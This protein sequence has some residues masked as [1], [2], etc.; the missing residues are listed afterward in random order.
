MPELWPLSPVDLPWVDRVDRTACGRLYGV[1]E[2]NL[3]EE[4]STCG[5]G[6]VC[7]GGHG[8]RTAGGPARHTDSA[9]AQERKAEGFADLSAGRLNLGLRSAK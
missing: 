3:T 6:G 5:C 4:K 8:K 9:A 7:G 1:S 2:K